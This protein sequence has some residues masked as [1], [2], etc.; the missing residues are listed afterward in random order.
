MELLSMSD[1]PAAEGL[2]EVPELRVVMLDRGAVE[3]AFAELA[4]ETS[5]L[6]VLIKGPRTERAATRE[7]SLGTA[8]E[9]FLG[10]EASAVQIHYV[11][12]GE[13]WWATL[14]TVQGSVRFVRVRRHG[15]PQE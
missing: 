15:I 11:H 10:G 5:V 2:L 7:P 3:R 13:E 8:R 9:V 14:M 6:G 12:R 4:F 1:A